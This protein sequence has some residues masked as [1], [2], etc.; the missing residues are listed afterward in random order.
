MR[1]HFSDIYNNFAVYYKKTAREMTKNRTKE[2]YRITLIGSVVNLILL[3]FKFIAGIVGHSSAMIADA[4]HSFSDFITDVIV[5]VFV[6]IAGKPDDSDHDYGHGKYE[7]LAS[8]LVGVFLFAVGI[9]IGWNGVEKIIGF[10]KGQEIEMPSSIAL[11][12]A[13]ISIVAKELLYQYTI[14]GGRSLGSPALVANAWHHRSDALTSLATL[15]GI[16]GAILLGDRW[17]VLDPAAAVIVSLFIIKASYSLMKPGIDELLEK[18]LDDKEKTE[19]SAI[20]TET[21]GV[22]SFHRLRTR[23]IGNRIAIDVHVKMPGDLSLREAHAIASD[24]E[25][26]IKGR[27]GADTFVG[28]HM[29]PSDNTSACAN[30]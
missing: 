2:I 3:I 23:R 24:V 19:I 25:S 29:E 14:R 20:I 27:Y 5:V 16:G 4:V 30:K 22:K 15:V 28:I 9:G 13:V 10:V 8:V 6:R 26:A 18:S 7:T 1:F 21:P 12:A 17:T 11:W